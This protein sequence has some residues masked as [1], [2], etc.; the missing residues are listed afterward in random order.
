MSPA[1]RRAAS[2]AILMFHW[3]WGTKSQDSVHR[4]QILKSKESRSGFEPTSRALFDRA[5][6]YQPNALPLGQTG[7]PKSASITTT[8]LTSRERWAETTV[9]EPDRG[10]NMKVI[11]G[12]FCLV[13][14]V[15]RK[16]IGMEMWN[17]WISI[18]SYLLSTVSPP[19]CLKSSRI[20]LLLCWFQIR[21]ETPDTL[22]A[23]CCCLKR[24]VNR[25][26]LAVRR[27]LGW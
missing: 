13:S 25:S 20:V 18:L 7:S 9:T 23:L 22:V 26:G 8:L 4:P 27:W 24:C 16:F 21:R 11:P 1:L 14:S 17:L 12:L 2:R 3:L 10:P 15:R 19:P 5:E 6:A